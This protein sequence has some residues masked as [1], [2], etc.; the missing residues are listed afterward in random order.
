MIKS[1]EPDLQLDFSR[2]LSIL[3]KQYLGQALSKAVSSVS[4]KQV[5][6]DL[7][8]LPCKNALSMLA[9]VGLRGE[10]AFATPTILKKNPQLLGYYRLLYGFS[11]K[12]FYASGTGYSRFQSMEE[13]N[14][15]T[16]NSAKLLSDLCEA[17]AISGE[18]LILGIGSKSLSANLLHELTLL[19]L[20]P[21][22]RG[23]ANVRKGIAA[24][25]AVVNVISNIVENSV[26]DESEDLIVV[27]N[28]AGRLVNIQFG[29]DPDIT[30]TETMTA[31]QTR[32]LVVIEV[33]GGTDFS[34]IHNRI[35]EAEK[36]H[37][38][39]K[40]DGFV[41]C[42]TIVNVDNMNVENARI[43]SPTTNQFYKISAISLE[44]GEEYQ[45]FRNRIMA[46]T[47]IA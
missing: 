46:L 25:M 20:G 36:S 8:L 32:K 27:K 21:Q 10:R 33:K 4:L 9:A 34:N 23:G 40:K 1:L 24:T 16:R 39:A 3:R 12:E 31:S 22:L 28:A 19:T 42:W 15:L 14:K 43:E 5:N 11:R 38:K 7:E 37:Q 41:E 2:R 47:G 17:L 6:A 13:D 29:S 30:I 35:G 26:V 45:D 18:K 44:S